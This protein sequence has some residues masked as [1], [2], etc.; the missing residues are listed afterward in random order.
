MAAGLAA[1]D[2]M[3]VGDQ[4]LLVAR[5]RLPGW[6]WGLRLS[7][8][9]MFLQTVEAAVPEGGERGHLERSLAELRL[10]WAWSCADGESFRWGIVGLGLIACHALYLALLCIVH[11]IGPVKKIVGMELWD[12]RARST[13]HL[14]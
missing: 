9:W 1:R 5:Q 13:A 12:W 2:M 7:K 10:P 6:C 14:R 3:A 4:A 8:Q 11:G